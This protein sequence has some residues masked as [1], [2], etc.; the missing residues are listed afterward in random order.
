MTL[1][2]DLSRAFEDEHVRVVLVD[3][4][5]LRADGWADE[6]ALLSNDG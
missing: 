1:R 4:I 2:K 6:E 5:P 3:S